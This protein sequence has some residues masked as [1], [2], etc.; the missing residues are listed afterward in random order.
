MIICICKEGKPPKNFFT[1]FHKCLV[2]PKI[3][4]STSSKW[5]RSMTSNITTLQK[6][7]RP[8]KCHVK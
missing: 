2:P 6:G 4:T 8:R 5:K 3:F 1:D 7:I